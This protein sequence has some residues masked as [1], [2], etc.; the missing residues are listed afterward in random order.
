MAIFLK[1]GYQYQA[2]F[3]VLRPE[4][5]NLNKD[6][7]VPEQYN[8]SSYRSTSPTHLNLNFYFNMQTFEFDSNIDAPSVSTTVD[9][10]QKLVSDWFWKYLRLYMIIMNIYLTVRCDYARGLEFPNYQGSGGC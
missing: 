6:A 4:V 1:A 7:N 5:L 9:D 3:V 8:F 2:W 10:S